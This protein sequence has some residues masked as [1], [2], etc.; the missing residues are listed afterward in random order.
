MTGP[1]TGAHEPCRSP[2]KNAEE[3]NSVVELYLQC[4]PDTVAARARVDM[5]DQVR[6]KLPLSPF[7][8][9]ARQNCGRL[10]EGTLFLG[11]R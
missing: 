2:V 10:P 3:E 9:K 11:C 6:L 4:Q 8:L 5:V 1:V 7:T